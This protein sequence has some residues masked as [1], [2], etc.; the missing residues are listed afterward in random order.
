MERNSKRFMEGHSTK[1]Y[2]KVQHVGSTTWAYNFASSE[3]HRLS[4]HL[5]IPCP[6]SNSLLATTQR[7]LWSTY[8]HVYIS[9]DQPQFLDYSDLLMRSIVEDGSYELCGVLWR[10]LMVASLIRQK[11]MIARAFPHLKSP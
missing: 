4:L 8:Q 11:Q 10:K 5:I 6:R 3:H 2:L 7:N 1:G 9:S